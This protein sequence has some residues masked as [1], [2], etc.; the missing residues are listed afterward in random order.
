MN[1]ISA[2]DGGSPVFTKENVF[3]KSNTIGLEEIEAVKVVMESGNLSQY[4][5]AWGP[6]FMGGPNVQALELEWAAYFGV[7]NAIAVNSWT[8]GL[9]AAVGA[10]G[11]EPGDEVIVTP[12]TM[13]ATTTAIVV[14]GGIPIFADIDPISFC[15]SPESV[16]QNITSRTRAIISV[17]IFGQSSDM[18]KLR[19]IAEDNELK[20]ISD[21]AQAPGA[22]FED[23]YAGT[24]ADIGGFSL[25]YHKHIHA[26]EGGILV[27]N[28]DALAFKLR[29]IRN[30]AESIVEAANV[31]DLT[32][33]VGFN[34]R[35]GE[36]QA[37]IARSQLKKLSGF[38]V[39]KQNIASKLIAGLSEL[40]GLT[41]PK[42]S[43]GNSH[44]YYVFA[45]RVDTTLLGVTRDQIYEGLKKEGVPSLTRKY[46]NLHLLPM[47]KEKIAFGRKNYPWSLTRR[48]RSIKYQ[49][50]LCPVAERIQ[51]YEY[52][53]LN[54]CEYELNDDELDGIILAFKKVWSSSLFNW[55]INH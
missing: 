45:M 19:A 6:D 50:D 44:V 41:L 10:L 32:N 38:V 11:I 18:T 48:G 40:P 39:Q 34:F 52:L 36:I 17:D 20:I 8:S 23:K 29:L 30:H 43:P 54:I 35:M 25:N 55:K 5:G 51:N 13:S 21:T 53:G 49:E 1:E 24:L 31:T 14:W 4:L 16:K 2:L 28:D 27:T 12:W 42:T 3:K 47:F 37:A 33:M 7:Q 22:T 46:Q 26:G 9:I 15:I